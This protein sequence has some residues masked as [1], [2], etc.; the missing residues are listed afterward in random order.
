MF[1]LLGFR[2]ASFAPD[3]RQ[4]LF[5]KSGDALYDALIQDVV[6]RYNM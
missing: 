4:L 1:Y 5:I 3:P 2:W 6:A